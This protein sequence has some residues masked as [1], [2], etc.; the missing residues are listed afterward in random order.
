MWHSASF[1]CVILKLLLTAQ[2]SLFCL[3]KAKHPNTINL[4][5]SL[6]R[7]EAISETHGVQA[8]TLESSSSFQVHFILRSSAGWRDLLQKWQD[9]VSEPVRGYVE[10]GVSHKSCF[11]SHIHSLVCGKGKAPEPGRGSQFSA[12]AGS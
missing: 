5:E 12:D 3:K 8:R 7:S 2:I 6:Q 11:Q 10:N 1:F 4:N 9:A